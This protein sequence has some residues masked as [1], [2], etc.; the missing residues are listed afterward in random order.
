[1]VMAVVVAAVSIA[2]ATTA[3]SAQTNADVTQPVKLEAGKPIEREMKGAEEH[4]YSVDIDSQQYIDAVVEQRGIDVEVTLTSPDGKTLVKMDSPN[5]TDG[6]EPVQAITELKGIHRLSVRA[7]EEKAAPGK[8][9]IRLKEMRAATQSDRASI[10]KNRVLSEAMQSALEA[11]GLRLGGKYDQA[12]QLAERAL[13][14][15]ERLKAP[16]NPDLSFSLNLL[17]LIYSQKGEYQRAE[18]MHQRALEIWERTLGPK[19]T[20]VAT[21]LNNLASVVEA[22]GDIARAESLQRR[23]LTI[24]ENS[25][26]P[27]HPD[28]ASSLN[29]LAGLHVAKGEFALAVQLYERAITIFDK[30]PAPG[31]SPLRISLSNLGDLYRAQGNYEKAEPLLVRAV[32]ITERSLGPRHPDLAVTLCNLGLLHIQ[33]GDYEQAES[34]FRRALTICETLGNLHPLLADSLYGL[35]RVFVEKGDY[36]AAEAPLIRSLTIR[37]RA[38][39]PRH[40]KL[41]ESHNDLAQLYWLKGDFEKAESGYQKALEIFENSADSGGMLVATALNNLAQVYESRGDHQKAESFLQRSLTTAERALGGEHELVA[42]ALGNLAKLYQT[43]GNYSKAEELFQRF[44]EMRQRLLDPGHPD[45]GYALNN[46]AELYLV[47]G[48]SG[49]AEPLYQQALGIFERAMGEKHVNVATSLSNLSVLYWVKGDVS[50]AVDYRI[51]SNEVREYD[52]ARNLVTG[53]ERQKLIYLR[54]FSGDVSASVSLHLQSAPTV[55]VACRLALTTILRHKGRAVDAMADA[56]ATLRRRASEEDRQLLGQLSSVRSERAALTIR[57]PGNAGVERYRAAIRDLEQRIERLED[58]VSQRSFEFRAQLTRVT[59]DTVQKAV[60]PNAALVEFASYRPINTKALHTENQ[61]GPAHYAAYVLRNRGEPSWV[62][63]GE[64]NRID[65]RIEAFRRALRSQQ[66][67]NVKWLGRRVDALLMQPVRRLLGRTRRILISPDGALNLVPFAALVDERNRYLVSRYTFTYLSSGRDL[68]RLQTRTPGRTAKLVIADPDFGEKRKVNTDT[69]GGGELDHLY[70]SPLRATR[71]EAEELKRVFPDATVLT[72]G[73]ATEEALKAA[74]RPSI[75]HIA[76]HGFFLDELSQLRTGVDKEPTRIVK[77]KR[78]GPVAKIDGDSG[79]LINPLLRSGLGLA[80]ANSGTSRENDDGILTA[81]EA[82]G[83]DLWGTKLVV[84]SACD[85]GVG[86][87]VSGDGVYGLRRALVLA[88][89]ESQMISLWPV[90]DA[91]TA[92]LMQGYYEALKEG[93]GRS[94]ALRQVQLRFLRGGRR[95][96]PFYWAGFIQSGEWAS[97]DGK[98]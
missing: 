68:L 52:L 34:D 31:N 10:E 32:A 78:S 58:Q 56:I 15:Q 92:E 42:V 96:H 65:D 45:I 19:H 17:G 47:R 53:S 26:G 41:G 14:T 23:A 67:A 60:P 86:K 73:L 40:V 82:T 33:M 64:A 38:F 63:L 61:Y 90:S 39:G 83:L 95:R 74:D 91:G 89:S 54:K 70:F 81:L 9:E 18:S 71:L 5:G 28:V 1:M 4:V 36:A 98:R 25:L 11:E 6:P 55:P 85:T 46:L 44:L 75:L 49:R 7:L 84:L 3:P 88:G 16:E 72:Q 13:A 30:P 59:L 76:T 80:G 93:A 62:D 24:R 79:S 97:L 66:N 69:R 48:D 12:A 27:D 77:V 43:I 35:A 20:F 94:A 57:G 21:S 2:K 50:R 51:R 87:V 8:Y 29:N 37:E 22:R